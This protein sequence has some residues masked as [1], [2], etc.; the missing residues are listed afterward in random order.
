MSQVEAYPGLLSGFPFFWGGIRA[1]V[2]S[3][4]AI[5]SSQGVA[6]AL[7]VSL[8]YFHHRALP[9]RCSTSEQLPLHEVIH[10]WV[11]SSEQITKHISTCM[12][13]VNSASH[14]HVHVHV[15][16]LCL[17]V[18]PYVFEYMCRYVNDGVYLYV[19]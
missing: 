17:P 16:V 9:L 15:Y 19:C 12:H 5:F 18:P 11:R 10:E 14:S 4:F 13:R 3:K 7:R 1:D 2:A 6:A 8:Q